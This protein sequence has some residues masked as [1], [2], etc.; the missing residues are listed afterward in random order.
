[1]S[2]SSVRE[3]LL[4]FAWG[5][6]AEMGPKAFARP[7]PWVVDPEPLLILT[8]GLIGHDRR[9]QEVALDWIAES[10]TR[11][12]QAR[13]RNLTRRWRP[14]GLDI[15]TSDL[16][17]EHAERPKNPDNWISERP[18]AFGLRLRASLGLGARTEI[19]RA[20]ISN[21]VPSPA[22][23]LALAKEAAYQKRS[24][25][26][27]L[28]GLVMGGALTADLEGNTFRYRLEHAGQWQTIFGPVPGEG[29]SFLAAARSTWTLWSILESASDESPAVRSVEARRAI[30]A[31]S[32][33]LRSLSLRLPD[34][35]PGESAWQPVLSWTEEFL[36]WLR[37]GGRRPRAVV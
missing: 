23:A 32:S 21:V 29:V 3:G 15:F 2:L 13:L 20:L 4:D 16:E 17:R 7:T 35:P 10:P 19:L 11:I 34:P 27:A 25:A 5:A 18:G 8:S 36:T 31:A 30:E 1:M 26:D 6:W 33:D 22:T 24:V 37:S 28:A 9:L 12:S 14:S